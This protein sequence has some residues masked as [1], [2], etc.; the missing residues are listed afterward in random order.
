[1]F[2]LNKAKFNQEISSYKCKIIWG[3]E[4]IRLL[5]LIHAF[6]QYCFLRLYYVMASIG[7]RIVEMKD[8]VLSHND[9]THKRKDRLTEKP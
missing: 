6:T 5:F 9:P 8:L 3:R 7:A 2:L 1:M 4:Q